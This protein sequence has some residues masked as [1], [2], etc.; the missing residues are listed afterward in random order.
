LSEWLRD[1][2][3]TGVMAAIGERRGFPPRLP[4]GR[5]ELLLA[6]KEALVVAGPVSWKGYVQRSDAAA[7]DSEHTQFS[8]AFAFRGRRVRRKRDP[9][10]PFTGSGGP[11]R[12]FPRNSPRDADEACAHPNWSGTQDL[13]DSATM[14]NKG[15]EVI[16]ARWLFGAGRSRSK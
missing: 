2:K 12:L 6:N 1:S 5:Q 4:R 3:S 13:V 9:Q 10:D 16:E 7:I 11:F 15:L 8:S 14:M